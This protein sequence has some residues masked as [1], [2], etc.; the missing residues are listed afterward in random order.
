ME[1]RSHDLIEDGVRKGG[2]RVGGGSQFD[3]DD[4][5]RTS[6]QLGYDLMF[7]KTVTHSLHVGY[8][9]SRDQ[10]DLYR[11]SNGWGSVTVPG[12]RINCPATCPAA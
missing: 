1:T 11:T 6:Y 7:G 2:G 4:F 8:Q 3:N 5:Y 10:E 9:Y 12:G